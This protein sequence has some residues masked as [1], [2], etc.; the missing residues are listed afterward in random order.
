[1]I[2]NAPYTFGF[3]YRTQ[4]IRP[5]APHCPRCNANLMPTSPS[6]LGAYYTCGGGT[7]RLA[8]LKGMPKLEQLSCP[9]ALLP[10]VLLCHVEVS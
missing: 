8:V 10:N 9:A 4:P 1:M 3:G 5:A 7:M 2:L 6:T